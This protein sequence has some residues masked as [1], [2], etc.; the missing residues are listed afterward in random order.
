MDPAGR[1]TLN[2]SGRYDARFHMFVEA[3]RSPD[4]RRLHFMR[5]LI[6]HNHFDRPAAGPAS[7]EFADPPGEAVKPSMDSRP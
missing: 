2:E 7:G 4:P 1:R 5:W 6:E 3:V